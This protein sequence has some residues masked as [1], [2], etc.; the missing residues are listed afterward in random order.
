MKIKDLFELWIKYIKPN[1]KVRTF[2]MYEYIVNNYI[3]QKIGD[4]NLSDINYNFLQNFVYE[5]SNTKSTKTNRKLSSNTIAGIIQ[6]LKS[7]FKFAVDMEFVLKNP[8]KKIK[9]PQQVEK[10]V[11]ALNREEQKTLETYCI[12]HSTKNYIGIIVSLYT[13]IRL[14][15]LLALRW[16]DIDFD[17]KIMKI[18]KTRYQIIIDGKYTNIIDN[19]KTKKSN[20]IIP[21]PC[22]LIKMLLK[23][24]KISKSQFVISNKKGEMVDV[25]SY[26]RTFSSILAKCNLKHY[27]YHSLRHTYATRALELGVDIKT[28]S[29]LLGH[30][31]VTITLNRYTHSLMEHKTKIMNKICSLLK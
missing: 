22:K 25:R 4:K 10:E 23:Y 18:Q 8:S 19:P 28:L 7:G 3:S 14:G 30:S 16:D 24:K 17:K 2:K 1:V 21:L 9:L 26:Q 15:E 13:G 12:N 11:K 20:R 29:E 27:G 6:V 5:L 31:S